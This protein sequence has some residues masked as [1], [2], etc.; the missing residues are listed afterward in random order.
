MLLA[1]SDLGGE[2]GG[3]RCEVLDAGDVPPG[4]QVTLEGGGPGTPPAEISID[5]FFAV[6]MVVENNAVKSGGK[7]LTL[8][9]NPVKTKIIA[10]GKVR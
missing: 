2:G 8:L 3:E 1:A 6:P 10:N 5:E 9:G 7:A 4:T